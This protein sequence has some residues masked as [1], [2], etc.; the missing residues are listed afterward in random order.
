M[1]RHLLSMLAGALLVTASAPGRS[2]EAAAAPI[3]FD[4][5]RFDV[6]GNTLLPPA[7]IEQLLA[8][9]TGQERD[10]GDVQRA[11]EALE[12]AYHARGYNVVTVE[13]PEQE[14]NQGVVRFKVVQSTIGRVSVKNNQYFDEANIRRSLPALQEGRLP[15]LAQIS[16]GLK[17]GNENPAKKVNLKLQSGERDDEVDAVLEVA[18]ER[19]WKAMLNLD[20]TGTEQ[21]G[22]THAGLVLQNANLWGRD[23]VASL[24]YTTTLE[25]PSRV[26]VYGAGYHIPLYALGD[27]LD[28]FASY[29]N[30]DSGTVS[31]G[32]FDLAVSGKGAVYGG[33]YNQ[34]LAKRGNYESRLVYGLDYK[35]FKNSVLL[36][37][38]EL[39][40]DVTVHPLSLGYLGTWTL[41]KGELSASLTLLHNV[42]GGAKGGQDAFTLARLGAKAGYTALRFA[43]SA[44][45]PLAADWA[46]RAIVNGQYSADALIPGEQFG[47]GGSSS[48]RGFAEREISNDSGL[49]ANLEAY[50]PNLCVGRDGWNCRLLAFY[51]HARVRRNHALPGE[52]DGTSIASAG[53]GLRFLIASNLNLQIDYGH[54]LRAGA[55]ARAD[56]NRLHLRLGLSY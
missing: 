26:K 12:A 16:A 52:L 1:K 44:S 45:Y 40:N 8:R 33:R 22:K 11:L 31:A 55:T 51:D 46:L 7:Q 15:N 13:L 35:A 48:V 56:A 20:N 37:G 18:D 21:T 14:L 42:A 5:K 29:S 9:F 2:A 50:T 24:Q 53:L 17:L 39:G 19:P 54:V 36:L 30:V 32:V 41:D 49:G 23:H 34:N 27:S 43:A 3:R 6:S 38:Q 10:F 47:A 25:H 4:I 28:L